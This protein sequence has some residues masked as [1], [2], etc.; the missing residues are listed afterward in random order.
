MEQKINKSMVSR[1]IISKLEEERNPKEI[2]TNH[3]VG[4][5]SPDR[6]SSDNIAESF[7]PDIAAIYE[8]E[9]IVY[10]IELNKKMPVDKW[11][12]FSKHA[13]KNKGNFYLVIPKYLKESIKNKLEQEEVNAGVITFDT[14]HS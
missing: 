9:T 8:N 7:V 10:E 11:R 1:A 3:V 4:Y 2:K 5:N 6:L 13:R 14:D 12:T